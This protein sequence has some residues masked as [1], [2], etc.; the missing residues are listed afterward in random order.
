MKLILVARQHVECQAY[1]V[2]FLDYTRMEPFAICLLFGLASV[3][4]FHVVRLY[5]KAIRIPI[6]AGSFLA[7]IASTLLF[8]FFG[9]GELLLETT[10]SEPLYSPN[11]RS[12][13]R[14]TDVDAG[15]LGD[16]S[17]VQLVSKRDSV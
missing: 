6:Q 15:A 9:C 16:G 14:V 5:R 4:L 13:L 12:A 11:G 1:S 3:W 7:V 17:Y 10:H 2:I 8:L